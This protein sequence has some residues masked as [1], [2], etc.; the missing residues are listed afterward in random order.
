MQKKFSISIEV[1][2]NCCL[3]GLWVV[4]FDLF[5]SLYK[6]FPN[7]PIVIILTPTLG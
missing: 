1:D 6:Y 7:V 2:R 4:N 5:I 3:V